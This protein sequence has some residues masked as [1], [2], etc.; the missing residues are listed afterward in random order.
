M[1]LMLALSLESPVLVLRLIKSPNCSSQ[2]PSSCLL[3][4]SRVSNP[5]CFAFGSD[6]TDVD[7]SGPIPSAL[8]QFSSLTTVSLR[9]TNLN[10][11]L[12]TFPADTSRQHLYVAPIVLHQPLASRDR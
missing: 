9:N 4:L 12:S 5:L 11:A 2:A 8:G 1:P 3:L 10:A 7:L 6:V